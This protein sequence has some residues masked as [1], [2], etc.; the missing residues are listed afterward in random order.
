MKDNHF[1]F[2][3]QILTVR[4]SSPGQEYPQQLGQKSTVQEE[5][6]CCRFL[7]EDVLQEEEERCAVTLYRYST[8]S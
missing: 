6:R 4:T 8:Y 1:V 3:L 2:R 5:E 7:N